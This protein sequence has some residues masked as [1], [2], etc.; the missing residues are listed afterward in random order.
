VKATAR[1][2]GRTAITAM[3]DAVETSK[4]HDVVSERRELHERILAKN[5][6]RNLGRIASMGTTHAKLQ[7]HP[8]E[9]GRVD[10]EIRTKD[11]EVTLLVR[12]ETVQA[13]AELNSQMNDLRGSMREHGLELKDCDVD[14]RGFGDESNEADGERDGS[15]SSGR[16]EDNREGRGNR[17]RRGRGQRIKR[18]A[19]DVVV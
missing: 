12:T 4:N 8:Q 18:S 1:E 7:L 3:R 6:G 16:G 17:R 11:G 13:A 5:L 2:T 19:I 14:A 9:L 10:V 15:S